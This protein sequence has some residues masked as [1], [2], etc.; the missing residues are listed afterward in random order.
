MPQHTRLLLK[1]WHIPAGHSGGSCLINQLIEGNLLQCHYLLTGRW[2][3]RKAGVWS[4][5]D[6]FELV[7]RVKHVKIC[8]DHYM[9]SWV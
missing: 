7:Q 8:S 1:R 4:W 6:K 5:E 2:P 3:H 9:Y